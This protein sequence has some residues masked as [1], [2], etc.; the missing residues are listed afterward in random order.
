ILTSSL[1]EGQGPPTLAALS[2]KTVVKWLTNSGI[3]GR[4]LSPDLIGPSIAP[5]LSH[6]AAEHHSLAAAGD[7][8]RIAVW[9]ENSANGYR[10]RGVRI[11]RGVPID[12]APLDFGPAWGSDAPIGVGAIDDQFLVIWAGPDKM[13]SRRLT[14]A[15]YDKELPPVAVPELNH[16]LVNDLVITTDTIDF[17]VFGVARPAPGGPLGARE[18]FTQRFPRNPLATIPPPATHWSGAR[19]EVT[20]LEVAHSG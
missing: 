1:S 5:A 13:L 16:L 11:V 18:M 6:Y 3:E 19:E 14:A 20:H 15:F 4:S 17:V 2:G 7:E 12:N 10:A 8:F 9:I